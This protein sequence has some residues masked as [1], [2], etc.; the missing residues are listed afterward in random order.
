[1]N[2]LRRVILLLSVTLAALIARMVI[3]GPKLF[4]GLAGALILVLLLF[5]ATG[6]STPADRRARDRSGLL[7]DAQTERLIPAA[8]TPTPAGATSTC[9]VLAPRPLRSIGSVV[10]TRHREP[11]VLPFCPFV[12]AYIKQH[13][14]YVELVPESQREAF[15]L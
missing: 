13:R 4:G 8:T 15:G 9:A 2:R 7:A 3:D 11:A 5:Q 12:N 10:A 6:T 1:M 14:E